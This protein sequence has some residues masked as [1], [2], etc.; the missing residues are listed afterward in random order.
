MTYLKAAH[1]IVGDGK[2][3]L[4]PGWVGFEGKH[5]TYVGSQ[6]PVDASS[7]N[8]IDLGQA[9]LTP[10]LMNI[11]DHISRKSLRFPTPGKT[12][13]ECATKLMANSQPYLILHSYNNMMHYLTDEG[14]TY[15]RDQ[16]LTGYTCLDLR[17]A[18]EEGVVMG[19]YIS[20]CGMSISITGG[21]CYR[22]S[23]ECDGPAEVMKAVR[24]QCS[25]G[26]DVIKF[27][28]SGGLEHFPDEDPSIPQFTLEEL[29]AGANAAHDLGRDCAIHAYSNEGIRRAVFAGI[30]NIE[31][32][33]MMSE[34]LIEEMAKRG[35]HLNPT[36]TGIRGAAKAGP[37]AK[38]WDMLQE[39]VFSKQE[40][41]MRWAKQAGILI[42]A[43]TD[44]AGTLRDEIELIGSTLGET[45]VQALEHALGINAKIAKH[46]DMG[47][48]EVGRLANLAAFDGDLTQSLAP[49]AHVLQ[50]WK[51]GIPCK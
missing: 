40:Q 8:T 48:L 24:T 7:D 17:K 29:T 25:K 20:S 45:P 23:V 6:M 14:I 16:G 39:R 31:H 50:T 41:G 5:I 46:P 19:P 27:M 49:L 44:T 42:G 26:A 38:Y 11:H 1:A 18:I 15:V 33:C 22:Q 10:G 35:T 2:T 47:L 12:F 43:G 3:V 37:N 21:H 32:G 34:D 4:T 9:T 30:D 51:D 28:G 36:M 13:G